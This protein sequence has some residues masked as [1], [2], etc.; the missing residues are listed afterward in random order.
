MLIKTSRR[1]F[2]TMLASAGVAAPIALTLGRSA[3]AATGAPK[4]MFLYVPDAVM[5]Q[6]WHPS[7]TATNFP[8][9]AMS[10]PLEAVR[11]DVIFVRGTNMYAGGNTH[12]GGVAK[13][14][15]GA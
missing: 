10:A 2:M 4:A 12:E 11:D 1:N 14:I 3:M 7:D 5:P 8:L 13:F 9:P 6:A 15:T